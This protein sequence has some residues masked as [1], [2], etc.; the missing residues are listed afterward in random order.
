MAW[1]KIPMWRTADAI[2]EDLDQWLTDQGAPH[3]SVMVGNPPA[4]WYHTNRPA[5]V[6][7]NGDASMLIE[8]ADRYGVRY[9]LLEPNHPAPLADLHAGEVSH[10]RLAVLERWPKE[11]AVLYGVQP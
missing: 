9:V 6:V 8:T 3:A 10:P 7:P 1:R 2:Y 11:E 4:F 5:I